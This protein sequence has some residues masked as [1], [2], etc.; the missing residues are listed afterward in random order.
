MKMLKPRSSHCQYGLTEDAD[1]H[2]VA[3]RQCPNP[4]KYEYVTERMLPGIT[5]CEVHWK[6]MMSWHK[7]TFDVDY[8]EVEKKK[9]WGIF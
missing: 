8:P 6:P 7:N 2:G 9:R 3:T 1:N 5:L 4:P